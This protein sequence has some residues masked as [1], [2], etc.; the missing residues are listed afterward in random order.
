MDQSS[1]ISIISYDFLVP[2][3]LE[4]LVINTI[5]GLWPLISSPFGISGSTSNIGLFPLD[6]WNLDWFVFFFLTIFVTAPL[7]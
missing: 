7:S 5:H 1:P 2:I 4:I 6:L 3:K